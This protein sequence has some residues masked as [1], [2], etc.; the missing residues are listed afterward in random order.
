MARERLM[1][2]R[3]EARRKRLKE[4]AK[5]AAPKKQ[6]AYDKYFADNKG[7]KGVTR[8]PGGASKTTLVLAPK[9]RAAEKAKAS[10]PNPYSGWSNAKIKAEYIKMSDAEKKKNGM[11]MHKAAMANKTKGTSK[12][13]A[14][15]P[16]ATTTKPVRSA[17]ANTGT[18]RDNNFGDGTYG[19]GRQSDSKAT[20]GTRG[21]PLP[22]NPKLKSQS[23]KNL[24]GRQKINLAVAAAS[25]GGSSHK[26]GASRRPTNPKKDQTYVTRT[27]MTMV[28]T[29][30]NWKQKT[31]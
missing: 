6:S 31:K 13:A 7:Q 30:K 2:K 29:G 3:T 14:A 21:K 28:W 25:G 26:R 24:T 18:G 1:Q 27:G 4:A 15:K 16:A 23:T 10:K 22:S 19:K 12:P 5:K 9:S 20:T 8:K 11:L 17:Q